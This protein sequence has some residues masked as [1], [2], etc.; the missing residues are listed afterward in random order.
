MK[1]IV[2]VNVNGAPLGA[3]FEDRLL[4]VDVT[5]EAGIHADTCVI[6][7]DNRGDVLDEPPEDTT[8]ELLMGYEGQALYRMGLFSIDEDGLSGGPDTMTISG[9][10]AD[11]VASLK[12]QRNQSWKKTTLGAVLKTVA[13]RNKL[14]PAIAKKFDDI[15]IEQLDQTYESDLSL[16]TRLADQ[17][18]ALAKPTTGYLVFVERGACVDATGQPVPVVAIDAVKNDIQP[19]WSYSKRGRDKYGS[20]IAHWADKKGAKRQEVKVGDTEPV[21]Y[22]KK[23]FKNKA[24]AQAAAQAKYDERLLGE[25]E[26]TFEMAIVDFRVRAETPLNITGLS[27]RA[28]GEWVVKTVGFIYTGSGFIARAVCCRKSDF[29]QKSDDEAESS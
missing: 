10:S 20:V 18:G 26:L 29:N 11:M 2:V 7:L 17:Y 19:G 23:P 25:Y 24:E 6:T 8:I 13:E 21:F 15:K 22:I 28:C 27:K 3:L 9:K 16:I 4:S 14:R 1:P 12:S 5:D